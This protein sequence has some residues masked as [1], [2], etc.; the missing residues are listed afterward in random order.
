MDKLHVQGKLR[1]PVVFYRCMPH[2]LYAICK[3]CNGLQYETPKMYP[4]TL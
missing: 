4:P 3:I 1:T 2:I